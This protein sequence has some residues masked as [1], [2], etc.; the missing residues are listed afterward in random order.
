MG[1]SYAD[2]DYSH[3]LHSEVCSPEWEPLKQDVDEGDDLANF[4]VDAE[5]ECSYIK[6]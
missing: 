3:R 6:L 5:V 1:T 2:G 4:D